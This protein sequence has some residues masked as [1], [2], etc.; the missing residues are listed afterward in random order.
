MNLRRSL[1][2]ITAGALAIS[3]VAQSTDAT[4]RAPF[5]LQDLLPRAFQ[6]NPRLE[7][8]VFT[9]VTPAGKQKPIASR[10]SPVYYVGAD[11]GKME[12]GDVIA[13]ERPPQTVVLQKTLQ[14]SLTQSGYLGATRANPPTIFIH[15]RWGSYNQISY[16]TQGF[17][18]DGGPEAAPVD[19]F[20]VANLIERCA[21]VGGTRF[22]LD[23]A[24][25]MR[26]SGSL[27]FFRSQSPTNDLLL[28][29][30]EGN[31]FFVIA[32]AYDYAAAQ[33]GERILLWRTRMSTTSNGLTMEETLPA[34]VRLAG[35]YFGK[36]TKEPQI[37]S[38]R[39]SGGRVEAGPAI[40]VEQDVATPAAPRSSRQGK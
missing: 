4:Y 10:E 8:T 40:V 15:Y 20:Q 22:A 11:G 12:M 39:L 24:R 2:L 23:A 28:S 27:Q 26:S 13:G 32:S 7:F 17:S 30:A 18:G 16:S 38:P 31:L 21:I 37:L 19:N 9:E 36:E 29:R 6:P 34:I 25:S 14:N 3:C 1:L 33:R 35:P 5:S